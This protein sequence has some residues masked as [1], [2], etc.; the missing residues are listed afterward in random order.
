MKNKI[1]LTRL[2][3]FINVCPNVKSPDLA[4]CIKC[5]RFLT[6]VFYLHDVER[7]EEGHP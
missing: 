7:G 1:V 6:D 4:V 3:L 5:A 2:R